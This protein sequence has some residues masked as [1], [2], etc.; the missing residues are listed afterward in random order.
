MVQSRLAA[1]IDYFAAVVLEPVLAA[2]VSKDVAQ[3]LAFIPSQAAWDMVTARAL[4][5]TKQRM[6]PSGVILTP[7]TGKPDSPGRGKKRIFPT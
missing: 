1:G 7:T 6:C 4:T 5:I 3:P 2:K